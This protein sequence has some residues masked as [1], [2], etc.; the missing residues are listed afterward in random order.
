MFVDKAKIHLRAGDGGNGMVSFRREKYIA[1]GGPDGGDGG[2]GGDVIFEVDPGMR[3]LVD[4]RHKKH[5]KAENGGNGGPANRTGKDGKD[6]VVKVPP[7][8]LVKEEETGRLIA[9]LTAAGSRAVAAKGG[10]GGKGNAR[11]ATPTRQ[12]PTFAEMGEQGERRWVV[13]ELKLI[14]D[15]GLVGFPNAGKSTILSR[16]S[17]AKPKIADYPFTT[18]EPNLGVVKAGESSFV[19]ADIPGLIKGAHKGLGLGHEFLRHIE[20][21]R[22]LIH[23]VDM[24]GIEGRNPID[25][26]RTINEE[27]ESYNPKLAG[28]MQIVAANKMDIPDAAGKL[29]EFEKTVKHEIFPVSA[30]T[31][32]GLER[33]MLRAAEL[34]KDI[35]QEEEPEEIEITYSAEEEAPFTVRRENNVYIVEGKWIK[36]LIG[37]VNL[38]NRESLQYFQRTIKKKGLNDE[39]EK[40][41]IK[42]GDTVRIYG[43]EFNYYK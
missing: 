20:R 4:F 39:L 18:L 40:M 9:D 7:G 35:P 26:F 25:D 3:T 24:A 21:T 16:V 15:V 12:V 42:E 33:L 22:I 17:A 27:L 6:I 13:L 37:S 23:V 41:G 5:L 29:K 11:F 1:A 30:A 32:E 19:L 31:G 2:R 36:R 10:K 8:T 38:D 28:R 43:T 34:L 14:S